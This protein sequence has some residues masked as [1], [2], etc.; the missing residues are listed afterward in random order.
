M[1]YAIPV[2]VKVAIAI[3]RLAT[4]S[5]MQSIADLYRIGLSTSQAAVSEFNNAV[6]KLLLKKFI[7]WPSTAVMNKFVDE[8]QSL[9]NIPYV[10]G[11]IDGSH[12]S[13]IAPGYT[14]WTTTITRDSTQ[15]FCRAWFQASIFSG[16]S[17]LDG[18]VLCMMRICGGGLRSECSVRRGS[19][20][21]ICWLVMQRILVVRGC[22]R[23]SK[24][25]K[26]DYPVKNTIR[27]LC[28]A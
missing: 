22:S 26:M 27:T 1:R 17:I 20:P 2:Q 3:S 5:S 24:V 10:V 25:T 14:L 7:R 13:I 11:A 6:T 18:L 15:S 23:H 8:F 4:G 12:I 28:R 16:T 9:H 19:Y 21:R